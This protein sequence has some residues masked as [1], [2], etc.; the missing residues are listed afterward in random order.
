MTISLITN[1]NLQN[2]GGSRIFLGRTMVPTD[3]EKTLEV[4]SNYLQK[5]LSVYRLNNDQ[6]LQP[7]LINGHGKARMENNK[8]MAGILIEG[9]EFLSSF[10][11]AKTLKNIIIIKRAY[12]ITKK[13]LARFLY[14][15]LLDKLSSICLHHCK[16]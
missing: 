15:S 4:F 7:A 3:G 11:F 12:E 8:N 14:T 1:L 13:I 9:L 6:L 16:L 10:G 2:L 5:K